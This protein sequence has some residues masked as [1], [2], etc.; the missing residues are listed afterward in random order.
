MRTTG[1]PNQLRQGAPSCQS[2]APCV[3]GCALGS[4]SRGRA[5]AHFV[6]PS[7]HDA[8]SSVRPAP[9]GRL[10]RE[11][12]SDTSLYHPRSTCQGDFSATAI[13]AAGPSYLQPLHVRE[14]GGPARARAEV[15][16]RLGAA[17]LFED[18]RVRPVSGFP[19]RGPGADSLSVLADPACGQSA[20]NP[21]GENPR[22]G[23]TSSEQSSAP[24]SR[25]HSGGAPGRFFERRTS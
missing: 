7:A 13:C 6:S 25:S 17:H 18:L 8:S 10:Q 22:F 16:P 2:C 19:F 9:S 21:R 20:R 11:L 12:L 23:Q 24:V 4:T 5:Q 3:H 15:S 14:P 1:T